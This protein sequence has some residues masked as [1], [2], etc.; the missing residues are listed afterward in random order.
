MK[1]I[2][3]LISVALIFTQISCSN[4]FVSAG[5]Q[6]Y[7]KAKKLDRAGDFIKAANFYKQA[8]AYLKKGGEEQKSNDC[9]LSLH[10][11][12]K[13]TLTYPYTEKDVR[14]LIKENYPG[15]T[16][17]RI[18]EVLKEGRLAHLKIG[19]EIFYFESFLNTLY[20]I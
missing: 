9:R 19:D 16:D 1:F 15:T 13:I 17:E 20:H 10:R 14:K 2:F 3:A 6:L 5:D 8:R 4:P 18:D 7:R 12:Q 11:I